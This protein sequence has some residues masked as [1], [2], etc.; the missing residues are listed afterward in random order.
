MAIELKDLVLT[1]PG[2]TGPDPERRGV[3][4]RPHLLPSAVLVESATP[5]DVLLGTLP[6][7]ELRLRAPIHLEVQREG[8]AVT[9]WSSDLNEFG[10]GPHLTE[11]IE[12]FQQTV[13]E[14]YRT[15]EVQQSRLGPSMTELWA[16]LQLLIE[17]RP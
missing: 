3:Q 13:I 17:R 1:E 16:L 11:A 6:A 12:D 10:Y 14:L 9:V 15:L 2:P 5:T 4:S 8:D 7:P